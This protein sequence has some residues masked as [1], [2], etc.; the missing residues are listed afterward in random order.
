MPV[1]SSQ[2]TKGGLAET[3]ENNRTGG[4]IVLAPPHPSQWHMAAVNQ[5]GAPY[6][7]PGHACSFSPRWWLLVGLK[8]SSLYELAVLRSLEEEEVTT[9]WV[10]LVEAS[11]LKRVKQ[12]SGQHSKETNFKHSPSGSLEP[13][14]QPFGGTSSLV[15]WLPGIKSHSWLFCKPFNGCRFKIECSAFYKI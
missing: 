4:A 1:L 7:T 10:S 2:E 9:S 8:V 14:T 5:H 6:P 11:R 12:S 13:V 3:N 15:H